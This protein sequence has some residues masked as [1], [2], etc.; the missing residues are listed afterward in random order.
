MLSR[1]DRRLRM[2][3]VIGSKL[4]ISKEKAQHF[5]QMYQPGISMEEL[6][7][8][9][10]RVTLVRKQSHLI[11]IS[12]ESQTFAATRPSTVL[13]EQLAVCVT[14][15][16]PVLLVGETG[17][18]K[19]STVQY[20]AGIT[21]EHLVMERECPPRSVIRDRSTRYSPPDGLVYHHLSGWTLTRG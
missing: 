11:Q 1:S 2:A 12:V 14:Q 18:G 10:G 21:G 9:V 7:V 13:L 16:E 17:T 4:N 8:S 20:L 6:E 19:T 5:V 3:E 15:G